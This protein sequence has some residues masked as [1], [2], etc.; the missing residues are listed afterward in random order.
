MLF[1]L[2]L[3]SYPGSS[4]QSSEETSIFIYRKSIEVLEKHM[5]DIF[6]LNFTIQVAESWHMIVCFD[7][8][9]CF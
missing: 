5:D 9:T 7:T 2:I 6:I 8:Q 4:S 3:Q 1:V